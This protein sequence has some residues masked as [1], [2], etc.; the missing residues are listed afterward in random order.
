MAIDFPNSPTANQ[1]YTVG[2]KTWTYSVVTYAI[3]DT[4]PAGGKIFITPSTAGN[5]TGSYFEA[6]PFLNNAFGTDLQIPWATNV[7]SNQSTLVSGADATAIGTGAQNTV[8]I[9]AQSGNVAA[10]CAAAYAS[11]YTYN[12]FSDW[13]LPSKDEL[14]ELYTNRASIGGYTNNYY[15]SSSESNASNAWT[16]YFPS[17]SPY[18]DFKSNNI[19]TRPVRSFAEGGRWVVVDKVNNASNQVYDVTVL[20][21]METN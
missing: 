4:G 17:G 14:T 1:T 2:G 18:A 3:G 20:L 16:V 10:T 5:S 15:W 12:G 9:V 19:Y 8:D 7:N 6:S 13:F 11:D 21:R